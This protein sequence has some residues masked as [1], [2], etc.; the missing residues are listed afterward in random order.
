MIKDFVIGVR[1][2]AAPPMSLAKRISEKA[3]DLAIVPRDQ[4]SYGEMNI[5]RLRTSRG[6]EYWNRGVKPKTTRSSVTGLAVAQ[7]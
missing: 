5:I 3:W 1:S 4:T 2:Q 6:P 7:L